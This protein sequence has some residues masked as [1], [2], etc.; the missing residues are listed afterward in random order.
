MDIEVRVLDS[1]MGPMVVTHLL[2]DTRD[3]MGANTVNTMAEALAPHI[4]GY[5]G[6]RVFLRILSNLSDRRLVR[7]RL[8]GQK[9]RPSKG[10]C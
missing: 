6:G 1:E 3:A 2:V 5:T 7:A 10:G 9:K 8:P 4:E